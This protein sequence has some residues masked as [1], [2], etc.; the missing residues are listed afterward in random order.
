MKRDWTRQ[1]ACLA[2]F[3][4]ALALAAWALL[5]L[6][7]APAALSLPYTPQA[8]NGWTMTQEGERR[9][10][11][12][13]LEAA[14][15]AVSAGEFASLRV[16]LIDQTG[17]TAALD[18]EVIF[19]SPAGARRGGTLT[20]SLPD[21]YAGKELT[22]TWEQGQLPLWPSVVL[23]S[24]ARE[25]AIFSA[26]AS[27]KAIPAAVSAVVALLAV[28]LF[29]LS[30]ALERF[31]W[32]LLLLALGPA[33][34]ALYWWAQLKQ[35]SPGSLPAVLLITWT[36]HV[37]FWL[38]PLFLITQV[39][40]KGRWLIPW[41]LLAALDFALVPL[42]LAAYP[43]VQSMP[44]LMKLMS[45]LPFLLEWAGVVLITV[46]TLLGWR[47]RNEFFRLYAPPLLAAAVLCAG[48]GL[49]SGQWRQAG[50]GS[51]LHLLAWCAQALAL[52]VSLLLFIRRSVRRDAELQAVSIR[53]ALTRE[54]LAQ[55]EENSQAIKRAAHDTRHHY[56][57]L[58]ELLRKGQLG[59]AEDYLD[60]LT[61]QI[62]A[63]A[64]AAYTIHPAVN[65]I[66]STMLARAGRQGIRADA[67]VELPQQLAI[68]DTDLAVLLMNL[69]ENALEANQKAPEGAEKWL[70]ITMHIRRQ[71]LYVGVENARFAPVEQEPEEQLF[72]STKGGGLHGY[73]LKAARS[74]ARKYGSEL[75]L[76]AAEGTFS[77][78]T[79]LLIP[80]P[81]I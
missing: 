80:R 12:R 13:T 29:C 66:L 67:R 42:S 52:A 22:L 65:A 53:D 3:L 34:Q 10:L 21:G 32:S 43:L 11:S 31:R 70:R 49:V 51:P 57:V 38:P 76:V 58:R 7:R 72:R 20:F 5:G 74:V 35:A 44:H 36:N 41:A 45:L 16:T 19:T 6:T 30:G 2:V 26:Q 55:M 64:P 56:A 69:L 15:D 24:P 39:E 40:R 48:Y 23:S 33:G 28:G 9:S 73:G 37:F 62:N 60:S 71:Y 4:L 1:A 59:R 63:D 27:V 25:R 68:P 50:P 54:Q 81:E 14:P 8:L 18:G 75:R 61:A 78:S 47:R 46:L 79:V 77:A 17:L